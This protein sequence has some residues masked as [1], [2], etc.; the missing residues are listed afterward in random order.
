MA[1]PPVQLYLSI[2]VPFPIVNRRIGC[3]QDRDNDLMYCTEGSACENLSIIIV[4]TAAKI[5]TNCFDK[6]E[7]N[8]IRLINGWKVKADSKWLRRMSERAAQPRKIP[9]LEWP[10]IADRH[11]QGESFAS[12]A[13]AYSCTPPAI[14]YIVGRES[15]GRAGAT[16][17]VPPSAVSRPSTVF[18]P[19]S[20]A[21]PGP[22]RQ[23]QLTTGLNVGLRDST[24]GE[25][26]N[27][28]VAF[29][30][31]LEATTPR[32][33]EDLRDAT[34]RLLRAVARVRIALEP[35]TSAPPETAQE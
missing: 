25:V 15:K 11:R 34:D 32:A 10:A 2:T 21:V 26:A 18:R 4:A 7:R 12:I 35:L 5:N 9:R 20:A 16:A 8:P 30:E 3:T 1:L 24:T 28:L 23:T 13:R 22:G 31:A 19:G 17:G 27:F 33:L 29:D 14:R 6:R